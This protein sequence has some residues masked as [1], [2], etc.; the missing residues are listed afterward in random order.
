MPARQVANKMVDFIEKTLPHARSESAAV[1]GFYTFYSGV[2]YS[3][4]T[5]VLPLYTESDGDCKCGAVANVFPRERVAEYAAYLRQHMQQWPV[6]FQIPFY[7]RDA[8]LRAFECLPNLFQHMGAQSTFTGNRGRDKFKSFSYVYDEPTSV[9]MARYP[10]DANGYHGCFNDR[11]G[12]ARDLSGFARSNVH[13]V[14]ECCA[15]CPARLFRF[16]ALS[17]AGGHCSCSNDFGRYGRTSDTARCSSACPGGAREMHCGGSGDSPDTVTS[18]VYSVDL[19][20]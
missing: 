12:F 8:K 20:H 18:A 11:L 1:A 16:C 3:K 10:P 14:R 7:T 17:M 13:S 5:T 2:E 6:D 19:V 15:F 9:L 4:E